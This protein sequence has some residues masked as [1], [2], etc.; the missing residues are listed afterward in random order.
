[1][2]RPSADRPYRQ[3]NVNLKI[4]RGSSLWEGWICTVIPFPICQR[5]WE[6]AGYA[7]YRAPI[8]PSLYHVQISRNRLDAQ[9]GDRGVWGVAGGLPG[10][11]FVLV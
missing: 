9:T 1:M 8:A 3:S 6:C 4:S 7:F 10:S 11:D 5:V 2:A